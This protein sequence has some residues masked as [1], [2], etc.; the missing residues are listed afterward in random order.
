M[1][2]RCQV[3]YQSLTMASV[4]AGATNAA[5]FAL[6]LLSVEDQAIA[7]ALAKL[8]NRKNLRGVYK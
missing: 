4:K 5:L 7:D 2:F 6:R 1:A 3:G 8:K